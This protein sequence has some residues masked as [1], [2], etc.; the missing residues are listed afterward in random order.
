MSSEKNNNKSS[1]KVSM[2]GNGKYSD[3]KDIANS[4]Y[5]KSL[6][7]AVLFI[8]FTFLVTPTIEVQPYEA[9]ITVT[10]A[11][12]IPPEIREQIEPPEE[13]IRPVVDIVIDD[14]LAGE[15]EELEIVSSISPTTL[16]PTETVERPSREGQTP[17]FVHYEEP[18]QPIRQVPPEYPRF[19]RQAGLEGT[20][21][22]LV[23]VLRDGSVGAIEVQQSLQSG[24]G[25]LD[26][27]AKDAVR[28]WHFTPAKSGGQ[29]LAVWASIP[30]RFRLD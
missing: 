9:E 23:E 6:S 22:L 16:D 26:Q 12:D 13:L 25:G 30:F 15:D 5:D 10:E 11:I 28:Q 17:R 14:D 8:L 4:Y 1:Q 20:V 2:T 7:L 29:P 19:A 27:A 24:P 21:I 18:P 3:W